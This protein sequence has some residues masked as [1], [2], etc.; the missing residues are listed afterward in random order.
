M[1]IVGGKYKGRMFNP[2]KTFKAR[3][4]TDIAKESLFNILANRIDFENTSVLDL[5]SGTGS[6]S[7]E[8]LSRGATDITMVEINQRHISF[9]YT[10]LGEL[11]E[12]ANVIRSDAFKYLF[13]CSK[14]FDLVFA[15]PPYDHP[16]FE[17]VP[18]LVIEKNIVAPDGIFIIEHPKQY[19]FSLLP[20]FSEIRNYG[21]V[22]F[23]IFKF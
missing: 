3:P 8:F 7:Y 2:G 13:R 14:Q 21:H 11:N 16:N 17:E 12:K 20:H 15:D 18:S 19:D 1:R 22:H 23:S 4:T 10:V 6:I 5:F 9:I